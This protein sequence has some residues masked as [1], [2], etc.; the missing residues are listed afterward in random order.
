[1]TLAADIQSL[2]PSAIVTLFSLDLNPIGIAEVLYFHAGVN[3]LGTDVTWQGQIY[4]RFP[5]QATGFEWNGTGKMPRPKLSIA[6]VTGVMD[7]LA[8]ANNDLCGAKVIRKKTLIKYLDAVNFAGGVNL[9]ADPNVHWNDEIWFIDRKSGENKIFIEWELAAPY[10]LAGQ[11]LPGRQV[12]S[13]VCPGAWRYRG[14]EC[15]Y[16]GPAVADANDVPTSDITKDK[17][18]HRLASC[19]LR[20]G[21]GAQ[22]P[23]GGFPAAGLIK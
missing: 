23:Y 12:V 9:T 13:N 17:C 21:I 1:M 15:G 18:G 14:P 7:A 4:T 20:F 5:I 6:N 10:D 11:M 2:N 3:A 19:I 22:L 16:A 8:M